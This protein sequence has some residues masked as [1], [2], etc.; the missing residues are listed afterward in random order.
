MA[1]IFSDIWQME[2]LRKRVLFNLGILA[3]YRLGIFIPAPGIDRQVLGAR[4]ITDDPNNDPCDAAIVRGKR[5]IEVEGC[6]QCGSR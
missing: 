3:V 6:V 5:R 4:R 2:D 1:N